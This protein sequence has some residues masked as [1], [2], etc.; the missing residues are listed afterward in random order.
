MT[1]N[2][3]SK[4]CNE[5]AEMPAAEAVEQL[6]A[7]GKTQVLTG[8]MSKKQML[9]TLMVLGAGPGISAMLTER[10]YQVEL[11]DPNTE[12]SKRRLA[13]AEEKRKRKAEKLKK[14]FAHK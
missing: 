10:D 14:Q 7:E 13:A 9:A 4:L 5:L 8:G 12:E 11:R 2:L 6:E 1:D 3:E